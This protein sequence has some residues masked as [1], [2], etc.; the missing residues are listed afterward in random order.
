MSLHK[1]PWKVSENGAIEPIRR[2]LDPR[3]ISTTS[4]IPKRRH[5]FHVDWLAVV[6]S[7]STVEVA[8]V[9]KCWNRWNAED[10][11]S[12]VPRS[13]R[14][15]RWTATDNWDIPAG[16]TVPCKC[17]NRRIDECWP[18]SAAEANGPRCWTDRTVTVETV[19]V[20]T[21]ATA[22]SAELAISTSWWKMKRLTM[23]D[24]LERWQCP[25]HEESCATSVELLR[26]RCLAIACHWRWQFRH[27]PVICHLCRVIQPKREEYNQKCHYYWN[28]TFSIFSTVRRVD[29]TTQSATHTDKRKKK[30]KKSIRGSFFFLF[31]DLTLWLTRR[32]GRT[33]LYNF[34]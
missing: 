22:V 6:S 34:P 23:D 14:Y 16:P 10:G 24:R 29:C 21:M 3:W 27:R 8:L 7:F 11:H 1:W 13:R 2:R 4:S 32:S 12:R 9:K 25:F 28:S 20:T 30:E 26:R 19:K 31:F 18:A 5:H 17:C 33:L 15:R